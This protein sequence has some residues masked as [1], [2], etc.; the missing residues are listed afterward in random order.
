MEN[1]MKFR[2]NEKS[3]RIFKKLHQEGLLDRFWR[4][5]KNRV[6]NISDKDMEKV[7]KKGNKQYDKFLKQVKRNPEAALKAVL[8]D[9]D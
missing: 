9:L 1:N 5:L 4:D 2:F 8:A 6:K 7:L 3:N